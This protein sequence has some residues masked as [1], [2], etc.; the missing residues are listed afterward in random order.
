MQRNY[1]YKLIMDAKAAAGVG[2]AFNVKPYKNVMVKISTASI[3]GGEGVTVK[4]QGSLEDTAP[5][6]SA[7]QS[8]S[9][10]WDY[11]QMVDANS[12]TPIEGDSGIAISGANDHRLMVV[13]TSGL[14]WLNFEL[15]SITGTV[16]VTVFAVGYSD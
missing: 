5:D 11:V 16:A 1:E 10:F 4:C 15:S 7:A 12:G 14:T 6:F 2:T 8:V 9:N 3:G 13:N